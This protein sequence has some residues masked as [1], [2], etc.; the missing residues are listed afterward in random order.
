MTGRLHITD[1]SHHQAAMHPNPPEPRGYVSPAYLRWA[2]SVGRVEAPPADTF[3]LPTT[4]AELDALS[5]TDRVRVYT[6]DR[7]LYDR[8]CGR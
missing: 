6:E 3:T 5:Y 4:T 8:L 7:A 2:E 1:D